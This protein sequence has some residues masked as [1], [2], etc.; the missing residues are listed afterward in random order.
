MDAVVGFVCEGC[1]VTGGVSVF[2]PR[3]D[4]QSVLV[5]VCEHQGGEVVGD[6]GFRGDDCA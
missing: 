1:G 2:V 4:L 5:P 3:L 6:L